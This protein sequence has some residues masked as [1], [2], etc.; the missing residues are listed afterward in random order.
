MCIQQLKIPNWFYQC[1]PPHFFLQLLNINQV[2][3]E[4]EITF[5]SSSIVFF[6]FFL[7]LKNYKA[8]FLLDRLASG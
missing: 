4:L 7:S 2:S 5:L 3:V 6:F 1:P 8:L